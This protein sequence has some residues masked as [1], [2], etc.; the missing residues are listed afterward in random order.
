MTEQTT[1]GTAGSA[2]SPAQGTERVELL[3]VLRGFAVFGI[4]LVNIL[5]YSAPLAFVHGNQWNSATDRLARGAIVF[6]AEGKFYAPFSFL[7]GMGLA[8]QAERAYS[9]GSRFVP[10]YL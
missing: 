9:R 6:L 2:L 4:L 5:T 7:F 10:L 3:D 1:V 8:L